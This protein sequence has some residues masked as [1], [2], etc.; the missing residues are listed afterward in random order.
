MV[1]NPTASTAA[2][3]VRANFPVGRGAGERFYKE[4]RPKISGPYR[5]KRR[6]AASQRSSRM[7]FGGKRTLAFLHFFSHIRQS[8]HRKQAIDTSANGSP[9]PDLD[10]RFDFRIGKIGPFRT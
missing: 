8:G 6:Q 7:A 1:S 2:C 3:S 9:E 4:I 5:A 10:I